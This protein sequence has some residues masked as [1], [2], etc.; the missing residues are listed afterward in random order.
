MCVSP[1][2][3]WSPL[4]VRAH[5]CVSVCRSA[6]RISTTPQLDTC[7]YSHAY[8]RK[9]HQHQLHHTTQH[10]HD[11]NNTSLAQQQQQFRTER[12][13]RWD[14]SCVWACAHAVSGPAAAATTFPST[15]RNIC[16]ECK[17]SNMNRIRTSLRTELLKLVEYLAFLMSK[18]LFLEQCIIKKRFQWILSY[19]SATKMSVIEARARIVRRVLIKRFV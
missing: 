2:P 14:R 9:T 15:L 7:A 10:N 19:K 18:W 16:A 6:L 1:Q 8:G 11:I 13:S 17:C 3:E 4:F 12:T 5:G